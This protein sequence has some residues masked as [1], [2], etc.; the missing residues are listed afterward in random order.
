MYFYPPLAP[1]LLALIT[2]VI[3]HSLAA[4][5]AIGIA[6]SAIVTAL[7]YVIACRLA[8]RWPALAASLAFV[9]LNMCAA[10]TWRANWIFPYAHAATFGLTFLLAFFACVVFDRPWLSLVFAVAAAWCKVDFA[11]AVVIVMMALLLVGK[12]RVRHLAAFATAFAAT[13]AVMISIFGASELRANIFPPVLIASS[14]ASRFYAQVSGTSSWRAHLSDVVL[15]I[16]ILAVIAWVSRRRSGLACVLTVLVGLVAPVTTA[17]F[18]ACGF[19][20]WLAL[21][22]RRGDPWLFA[23]GA[24]SIGTTLR[25]AL[26]VT[27]EWYGFVLIVP[28]YL[29]IAYA[30]RKQPVWLVL[31][32]VISLRGL[33]HAR[34]TFATKQFPIVTKR[35]VILDWNPDRAALLNELFPLLHGSV[36]VMPEGLTLNYFAGVPTPLR[37]H[38]FTP[39]E[40]GDP[41][42]EAEVIRDLA[43]HPPEQIVFLQRDMR[44]FAS[45]GFGTD[46]D[47]RLVA[48]IRTR[49]V[50]ER[51]WSR[52]KFKLVLLRRRA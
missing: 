17:F 48:F 19:L 31:L 33:A 50:V 5:T 2:S 43:A 29:L 28:L 46:Y 36:A 22:F 51:S 6:Q 20:Q 21:F 44:E 8:G 37:F 49:Y 39:V 34:T 9:M 40:T 16:A 15:V 32:L 10:S 24:L 30:A 41:N 47:Q 52:P 7:L 4:Y 12:L 26:N 18:R 13:A 11:V 23:L 27:P 1:Y 35:G 38:T 3:G 14:R 42:V 45:R 25:I